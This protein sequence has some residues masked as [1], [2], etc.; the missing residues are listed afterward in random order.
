[1]STQ[2]P[3]EIRIRISADDPSPTQADLDR[4][5]AALWDEGRGA[6]A[7]RHDDAELLTSVEPEA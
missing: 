6:D 2:S 1:M 4:A 3:L 5:W 7:G